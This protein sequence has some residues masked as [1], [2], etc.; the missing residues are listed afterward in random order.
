VGP[1]EAPPTV[2]GSRGQ[3]FNAAANTVVAPWNSLDIL[4]RIMERHAGQIAAV[5]LEPVL[6]NSGCILPQPGYL[7]GVYDLARH[8]GALLVFDEII[9][10]FRLSPGGAQAFYGVV[11]DLATFGKAVGGG[12]PLSVVAGRAD[13]LELMFG[14][15]VAFGGTFNGNPLS[16]A[17]AKAALEELARDGGAGLA[18][19]NRLGE[20][21][22]A[23]IRDLG[24]SHGLPLLVSGFGTA[25]A[26]HFTALRELHDYRDT[27]HDDRDM[28]RRFLLAA[29]EE[30]V[31]IVPDGRLYTSLAHTEKDRDETLEA[32]D[33]AMARL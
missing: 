23:G 32:L 11:P 12:L 30:G 3:V 15:G 29:L 24:R 8:H 7:A 10:G 18:A 6:C 2:P 22:M 1:L 25:F 33:R 5:I 21:L 13:I 27:L 31:Q 16:L 28:L 4:V 9:T 17:A 20:S 26:V 14:G 19:A